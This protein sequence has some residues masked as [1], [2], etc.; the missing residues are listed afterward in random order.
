LVVHE[1]YTVVR[2][3]KGNEASAVSDNTVIDGR[4]ERSGIDSGL[5]SGV[6]SKYS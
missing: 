3:D 6:R 2:S 4:F 5:S 1:G